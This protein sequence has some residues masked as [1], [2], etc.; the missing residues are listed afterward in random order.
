MNVFYPHDDVWQGRSVE[1]DARAATRADIVSPTPEGNS[2]FPRYFAKASGSH[3]WDIDGN[4]Y[5]DYNLGYGP[6]VLG[7]ADRR[8]TEAV[9]AE[10][11]N[12]NCIA[13]LWSKRQSELTATLTSLIPGGELAYLLKTG[14]DATSTAVRLS[15]IFTGR[16][17]VIRWGYNGWH[18]W[19]AGN[20]TGI[21][22][23]TRA[24]TILF[25][26][27]DLVSLENAFAQNA[28]QVACV[29]IMPF[30][31]EI[32]PDGHLQE[33]RRITHSHGALFILDEMRSGFRIN[34]GGIQ[35]HVGVQADL[36]TFSK[37]MANGFPIS[38]VVG[39]E[40]VMKCLGKTRISSTF[41][42]DPAPMAA[43]LTTISI[44]RDSEGIEY[45]WRVGTMFQEGLAKLVE[46]RRLP[47]EVVGYPPMPFL[48]FNVPD[49]AT[50]EAMSTRF[51][52]EAAR[53]GV[54]LHPEHQWFVSMA[55]TAE[56]IQLSLDACAG[57]LDCVADLME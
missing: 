52:V 13:P 14:S 29:L 11:A 2:T 32:V 51:A 20:P 39:R 25:D 46:A 4:S 28:E 56:D 57:A 19:A 54:L 33:I 22:D 5:V 21:P 45:L 1:S 24:E 38:A 48:R 37:A 31:D 42:A 30:G 50:R 16:Q 36:S 44:L 6:V 10:L 43:A 15:R 26:Y 7:H 41:Y 12:G 49:S 47:A 18:D 35:K 8:V 9:T 23:A 40:E 55:H 53:R 27:W 34:L 17:K 3:I